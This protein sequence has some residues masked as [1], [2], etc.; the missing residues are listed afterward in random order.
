[1]DLANALRDERKAAELVRL[2]KD[3][4]R[5]AGT[6]QAGLE[7]ELSR[8]DDRYS[9]EAQIIEDELKSARKSL[10]K[11]IDL[12]IKKIVKNAL[13]KASSTSVEPV[14]GMTSEEEEIYDSLLS[15]VTRGRDT[16]LA[17]LARPNTER[18]LTGK[19]DI[20]EEYSAV[21]L[22]DSVPTFI[23]VNGIRYCLSKEDVVVLPAVHVK[24]L[25]T[26]DLAREVNIPK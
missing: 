11:L 5:Q 18:P 14:E 1:L 21:R 16:I 25:C 26:K 7:E 3:F 22:L 24:N 12:R 13:R 6:Y 19:K 4:Y 20:A 10:S 8:I 23:G 9:V 2:D 15:T 17:H